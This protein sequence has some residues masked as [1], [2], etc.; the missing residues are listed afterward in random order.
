MVGAYVT[1]I[2]SRELGGPPKGGKASVVA[3]FLETRRSRELY[4]IQW[5]VPIHLNQIIFES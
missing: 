2:E 3:R 4:V 5:E 1:V